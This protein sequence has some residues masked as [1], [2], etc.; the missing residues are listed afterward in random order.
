MLLRLLA[1]FGT[2]SLLCAC[3]G[4]GPGTKPNVLLITIDTLRPDHLSCYGYARETSP[5]L[6]RLARESI[7]FTRAQTP[8]AKTTPAMASV[9]SGLYPH[10][11]GVRELLQ[12]IA[13]EIPLLAE[14]L[15]AA[16]YRTGAV[17]G[18][19]VLKREHSGLDRGFDLWIDSLPDRA[20]VPPDD[21]PQ[22]RAASLT[23][24]GLVALGLA[25]AGGEDFE[26]STAFTA[27]RAP[28]FLWLHYMDPH[29]AYDPPAEHRVFDHPGAGPMLEGESQSRRRLYAYNLP[30]DARLPD[31]RMDAGLTR[32]RYDGEIR[33]ADAEIGRLLEALR[34]GGR[35][36]NTVVIVTSD[37]GES[38]GEHDYWFEHGLYAYEATCRVPL[39]VRL[40]GGR[41]GRRP[42]RR[43]GDMSLVDLT[44]TLLD[45]L[46]LDAIGLAAG[47]GVSR[48]ALWRGEKDDARPVFCEKIAAAEA[49]GTLQIKAVRLGDWKLIRHFTH[50]PHPETGARSMRTVGE[51]VYELSSDP[52]EEH[53]LSSAP[54]ED[55]PLEFLRRELLRFVAQD[56]HFPEL[57]EL[58]RRH[59]DAIESGAADPEAARVLRQLGYL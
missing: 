38:L 29:G 34:A 6:D 51:Q 55:A 53:D 42:G 47:H 20:G 22:R 30:P 36:E 2:T 28:W 17:V 58:L 57:A 9:F 45:Y 52:R 14:R 44:P 31:G 59:R 4:P 16:G 56:R 54:P 8:R 5:H 26:P 21:A 41:P 50:A 23:D 15:R 19:F 46:G 24:A 7:L 3:S 27:D 35:L 39:I 40:P 48:L 13:P 37:H 12:P 25:A 10:G 43:E 1:L 33:Y 11:H 18:N 49:L 32:D